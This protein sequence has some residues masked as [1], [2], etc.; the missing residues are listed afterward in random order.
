MRK[1]RRSKSNVSLFLEIVGFNDAVYRDNPIL[2]L[3]SSCEMYE[4]V[5]DRDGGLPSTCKNP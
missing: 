2:L 1:L 3:Y 5:H 4:I